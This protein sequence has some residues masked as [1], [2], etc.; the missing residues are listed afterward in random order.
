MKILWK[1]WNK[2]ELNNAPVKQCINVAATNSCESTLVFYSCCIW[3]NVLHNFDIISVTAAESKKNK[4]ENVLK[5][6]K[7]FVIHFFRPGQKEK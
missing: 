1:K 6:K 2:T 3:T 4:H 7:E 5:I